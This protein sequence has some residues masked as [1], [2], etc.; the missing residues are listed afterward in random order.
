MSTNLNSS[1]ANPVSRSVSGPVTALSSVATALSANSVNSTSHT[2]SNL[3]MTDD[4]YAILIEFKLIDSSDNILIDYNLSSDQSQLNYAYITGIRHELNGAGA[5]NKFTLNISYAPESATVASEFEE[6]LLLAASRNSTSLG[7]YCKFRYGYTDA[8]G[9]PH[10]S[11]NPSGGSYYDGVIYDY[12]VS[13]SG[14][15]LSYTLYGWSDIKKSIEDKITITGKK[16]KP[17][18]IV[19]EVYETYLKDIYPKAVIDETDIELDIETMSNQSIWSIFDNLKKLSV[20][21][22]DQ[23]I[24]EKNE[25]ATDE[26]QKSPV[27]GWYDYWLDDSSDSKTFHYERFTNDGSGKGKTTYKYTYGDPH[28]ATVLNYQGEFNGTYYLA[29]AGSGFS[30]LN[31]AVDSEGD[32]DASSDTTTESFVSSVVSNTLNYFTSLLGFGASNGTWN[33]NFNKESLK[34][35][36]STIMKRL[37]SLAAFNATLTV[38]G[39]LTGFSLGQT[40]LDIVVLINGKEYRPATGS[41]MVLSQVNTLDSA[42]FQ[43]QYSILKTVDVKTNSTSSTSSNSNTDSYRSAN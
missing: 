8:Y 32:S 6:N 37:F 14:N 7:S 39:V 30:N 9:V 11:V 3:S 24:I 28:N 13:I 26:S 16:A 27:T 4:I 43:T 35:Y 20:N 19:K 21:S 22:E 15:S 41:Y 1:T 36:T 23:K 42:G 29:L 5:V 31:K 40:F 25:K 10:W 34:I 18:T 12:D 2:S 33:E 17:S 38:T